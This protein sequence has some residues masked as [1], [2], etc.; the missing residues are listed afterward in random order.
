MLGVRCVQE[1][2]G[3]AGKGGRRWAPVM[4][5]LLKRFCHFFAAQ[6]EC[7]RSRRT[8]CT[9]RLLSVSGLRLR[10]VPDK[11][12]NFS[13]VSSMRAPI[14]LSPGRYGVSLEEDE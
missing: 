8:P 7:R 12:L 6:P 1:I 4:E 10:Q 14:G 11:I 5:A 2:P 13:G 9:R 3:L